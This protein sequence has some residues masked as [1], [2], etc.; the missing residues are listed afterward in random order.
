[1]TDAELV[2]AATTENR[3]RVDMTLLERA[4]AFKTMFDAGKTE[5]VIA[6][7]MGMSRSS[8]RE[9]LG[10]SMRMSDN[11]PRAVRCRA[12]RPKPGPGARPHDQAGAGEL[13]GG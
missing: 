7:E 5:D 3:M 4:D 9:Y 2:M 8:V 1:M 11:H 13:L 12:R 10:L 6:L